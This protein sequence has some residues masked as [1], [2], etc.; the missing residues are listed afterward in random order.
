MEIQYRELTERLSKIQNLKAFCEQNGLGPCVKINVIGDYP[1]NS[2]QET[3]RKFFKA[4]GY[5][6]SEDE[7]VIITIYN[8]PIIG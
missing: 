7:E 2:G 1:P 4:I 5:E 8:N 6:F 3:M